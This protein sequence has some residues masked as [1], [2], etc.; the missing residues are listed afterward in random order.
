MELSNNIKKIISFLCVFALLFS[1]IAVLPNFSF[2]ADAASKKS[3]ALK[4]Y[5]KFLVRESKYGESYTF[6]GVE[7]KARFTI[8]Y[9]DNNNVPE[10]VLQQGGCYSLYIFK[11]GRVV[12]TD[13]KMMYSLDER[14]HYCP[15]RGIY[16]HV[17]A[18]LGNVAE[19]YLK[20]SGTNSFFKVSEVSLMGSSD[21]PNDYPP[22]KHYKATKKG[23][24]QVSKK[25]F[26]T[27]L[28]KL[29]KGKSFKVAKFYTNT[30]RNRKSILK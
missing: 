29:T 27:T 9:L 25:V 26:K 30:K 2:E 21:D 18:R 28:K 13:I 10:L 4:A 19:A 7:G 14:F 24:K 1:A 23:S 8:I 12:E 20:L 3:Q 15:K 11:K 16:T 6:D 17:Y 22:P 5:K